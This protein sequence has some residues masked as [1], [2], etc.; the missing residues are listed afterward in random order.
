VVFVA[1]LAD[2]SVTIG[3]R[4]WCA[5]GDYLALSWALTEAAKIRFAEVGITI[6]FPQREVR[7]LEA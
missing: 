1:A 4:V 3:M 5:T 2:S 7:A 6:P